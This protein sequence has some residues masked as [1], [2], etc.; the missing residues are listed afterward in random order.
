[1]MANPPCERCGCDN[2]DPWYMPVCD[3]HNPDKLWEQIERL[4]EALVAIQQEI[5]L[6]RDS[7]LIMHGAIAHQLMATH[8]RINLALDAQ[9]TQGER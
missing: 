5:A 2:Y 4:R 9:A 7:G 1:M 8:I 3:C 6:I